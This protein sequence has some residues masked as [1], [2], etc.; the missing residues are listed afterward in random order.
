MHKTVSIIVS[1]RVQGVF[2][3]QT[4][5][6]RALQ[7]GI[8]GFA[9]NMADGTVHIIATGTASALDTFIRWCYTG[10]QRASVTDV[11]VTP[12]ALQESETFSIKR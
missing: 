7:S 9:Q 6:E 12:V 8:T 5:Q 11:K 3:R 10:P 2:F 4:A 1:G